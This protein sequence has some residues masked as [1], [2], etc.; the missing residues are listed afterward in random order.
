MGQPIRPRVWENDWQAADGGGAGIRRIE[1]S[2]ARAVAASAAAPTDTR[3]SGDASAQASYAAWMDTSSRRPLRPARGERETPETPLQSRRLPGRLDDTT[4][5]CQRAAPPAWAAVWSA[6][7]HRRIPRDH[8]ETAWRLLHAALQC[9]ALPRGQPASD[10]ACPRAACAGQPANLTH[11]FGTCSLASPVVAWF[12]AVWAVLEPGNQP[13]ATF[14]VI[15]AGDTAPWR[16]HNTELW[17]RL[18]LR[19][20][21]ELWR[22]A[23]TLAHS[24]D[25][26]PSAVTARVVTGARADMRMDW[27]RA[28]MPA[29]V[30]ADCC[31]TWMTGAGAG[32]TPAA[33]RAR[34]AEV[35][36]SGGHLCVAPPVG[37]SSSTTPDIRWSPTTPVPYPGRPPD[38]PG[39]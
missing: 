5:V 24:P 39:Q 27:L 3:V 17:T 25:I 18:R 23:S 32:Q 2:W 35:W 29:H 16:P 10:A 1:A 12:C 15:A 31:G 38:G 33:A 20:L 8:R 34:F 30:L 4:D 14:S 22:S 37:A 11:I 21:H 13:P 7:H 9:N 36:C 6:L 28:S 19:L 26:P